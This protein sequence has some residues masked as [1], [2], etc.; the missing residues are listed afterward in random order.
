VVI[1]AGLAGI[2]SADAPVPATLRVVGEATVS[3][4]PDVAWLDFAVVSEAES[5]EAA[6]GRTAKGLEAVMAALH[7]SLGDTGTLAS[8]GY[9]VAP[10]YQYDKAT[11]RQ[12][13]EGY[14][15]R[16]GLLVTLHDLDRV[17]RVI[18]AATGAGANEIG[19]LRFGWRDEAPRRAEA[20]AAAA[21]D[22]RAR[23]QVL[24]EALQLSVVRVLS[25][26]ELRDDVPQPLMRA[27]AFL[28]EAKASATPIEAQYVSVRARVA[29][30]VEMVEF[31]AGG[32]H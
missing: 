17:G 18:D 23:V 7:R 14:S 10:R 2:A 6:V 30:A 13:L 26:E 19:G 28:A 24:A 3:A 25:V 8:E 5:A 1:C 16:G 21:R 22:A 15:A 32:G 11:S 9:S 4:A 31:A 12:R 29:L 20:L 27:Q